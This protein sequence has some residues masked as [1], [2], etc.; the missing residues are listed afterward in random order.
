[1]KN[2]CIYI[3]C[4]S[5]WVAVVGSFEGSWVWFFLLASWRWLLF[6][7]MLKLCKARVSHFY[8]RI[9][10]LRRKLLLFVKIKEGNTVTIILRHLLG[11][12]RIMLFGWKRLLISLY[13]FYTK[14]WC[15][16]MIF[17]IHDIFFITFYKNKKLM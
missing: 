8:T 10:W 16:F 13:H 2:W 14:I 5:F 17:L 9:Y 11:R 6:C 3:Y 15:T 4:R 7:D 1:M 12:L